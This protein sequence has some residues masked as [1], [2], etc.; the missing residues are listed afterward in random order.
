M[1]VQGS[2]YAAW[3]AGI[4][5]LG[6]GCVFVPKTQLD[7]CQAQ[8]RVLREQNRA[9]LAE[10]ENLKVHS[11]KTEEQLASAE[12][13]LA[14]T[15]EQLSLG[16][17]QLSSFQQER[18]ELHD[19]VRGLANA[20]MPLSPET[21]RRLTELAKRYPSLHF[22]PQSGVCKLDTDILFDTGRSEIKQGAN[23]VL[24]ELVSMLK[25][26][27]GRDL[28]V[29]V[30]GHTDDRQVAKKPARD[31]Y[32]NNFDL[33]TSRAK[34]VA[35]QLR[36]QGLEDHRLGVAGFAS[37]EPVAPNL[38]VRDRQKNRRVEIFVVAPEVPVVGWTDS[39]PGVYRE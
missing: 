14:T 39:I 30:V 15:E 5:L 24:G 37:H 26:P 34:A 6:S 20:R 22:D 28:R 31:Q 29:F 7:A 27:E 38:T 12:Q 18:G 10:I 32:A 35:D 23:Q 2:A 11:R 1:K 33:S 4:L 8:D 19:Q 25:T 36:K 21:N 9:Q 3:A 13:R 17:K 16:Q